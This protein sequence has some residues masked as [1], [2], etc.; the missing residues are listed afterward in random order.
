MRLT[1]LRGLA[2]SA[3]L[4][5]QRRRHTGPPREPDPSFGRDGRQLAAELLLRPSGRGGSRNWAR[6]RPDGSLRTCAP[7]SARAPRI[8]RSAPPASK[9]ALPGADSPPE[10]STPDGH[11][12]R[13]AGMFGAPSIRRYRTVGVWG[14]SLADT[15]TQALPLRS[16]NGTGCSRR[17]LLRCSELAAVAS[18]RPTVVPSRPELICGYGLVQPSGWPQSRFWDWGHPVA[19]WD[20][21]R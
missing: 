16:G 12:E 8:R 7:R 21:R 20:D 1:S 4:T 5:A 14:A 6:A 2:V 15:S 3:R 9:A 17:R 11:T 19:R 18:G 10:L 13:A